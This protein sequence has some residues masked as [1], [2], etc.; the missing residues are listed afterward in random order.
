MMEPKHKTPAI[1]RV[2][3][4]ENKKQTRKTH[5]AIVTAFRNNPKKKEESA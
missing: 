1:I 2:M 4:K 5:Q 3:G